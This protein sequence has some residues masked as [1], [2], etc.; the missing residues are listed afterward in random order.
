MSGVVGDLQLTE[1]DY[2]LHPVGPYRGPVRM[3]VS[4]FL[5]TRLR[6]RRPGDGPAAA[7]AAIVAL[8]PVDVD[9]PGGWL[10]YLCRRLEAGVISTTTL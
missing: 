4:P 10:L 3:P 5:D 8:V 2:V 9:G 7:A 1:A 6:L